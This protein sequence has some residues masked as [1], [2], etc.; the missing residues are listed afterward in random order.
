MFTGHFFSALKLTFCDLPKSNERFSTLH[1]AHK[2]IV[3]EAMIVPYSLYEEM[4]RVLSFLKGKVLQ[5][6]EHS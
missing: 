1:S 2:M 4:A 6:I 5:T 3:I